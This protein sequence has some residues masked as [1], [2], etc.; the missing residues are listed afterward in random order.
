MSNSG[1]NTLNRVV[2]GAGRNKSHCRHHKGRR[3]H[4][5]L[6]IVMFCSLKKSLHRDDVLTTH[7]L[8]SLRRLTPG[9]PHTSSFQKVNASVLPRSRTTVSRRL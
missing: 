5:N 3:T 2:S 1:T 9:S 7:N 4:L 8:E 6:S